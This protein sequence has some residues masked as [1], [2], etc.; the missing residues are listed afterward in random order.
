MIDYVSTKKNVAD[1]IA[2]LNYIDLVNNSMWWKGPRSLHYYFEQSSHDMKNVDFVNLKDSIL[3][4]CND[5]VK[6]ILSHEKNISKIIDLC[7]FSNLRKL[8]FVTAL[9]F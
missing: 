9:V 8:Y 5:E 2:R 7:R 3:T 6:N 1:I 4:Q